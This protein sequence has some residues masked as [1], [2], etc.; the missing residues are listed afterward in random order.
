MGSNDNGSGGTA[1]Q[2][3]LA[4]QGLTIPWNLAARIGFVGVAVFPSWQKAFN[5]VT[6]DKNWGGGPEGFFKKVADLVEFTALSVLGL[7]I[8]SD[9]ARHLMCSVADNVLNIGNSRAK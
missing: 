2:N 1:P 7:G 4:G 9:Q 3:P 6:T 5:K 8:A